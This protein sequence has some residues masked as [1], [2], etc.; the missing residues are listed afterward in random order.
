M[1][2]FFDTDLAAYK[3]FHITERQTVQF[4]AS[5]FNWVNHPLQQFDSGNQLALHYNPDLTPNNGPNG[6]DSQ[7]LGFLNTKTG[8]HA[9]RTM[10]LAIKYNF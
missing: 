6:S 3:T 2:D 9:Q 8:A 5:A 1:A 4:R 7:T 10:E